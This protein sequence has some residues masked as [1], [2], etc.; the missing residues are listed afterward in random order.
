MQRSDIAWQ[1]PCRSKLH[2]VTDADGRPIQFFGTAVLISTQ[3]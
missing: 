1:R 3:N 2:S